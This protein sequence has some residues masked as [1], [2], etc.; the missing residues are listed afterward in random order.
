MASK[1][2]IVQKYL[3]QQLH[4]LDSLLAT[5]D[6]D[7]DEARASYEEQKMYVEEQLQVLDKGGLRALKAFRKKVQEREE[8]EA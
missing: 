5:T 6:Y 7:Y 4:R 2:K 1:T 8:E 3:T